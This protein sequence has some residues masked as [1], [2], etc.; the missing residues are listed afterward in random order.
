M[1]MKS[2]FTI[3]LL[4]CTFALAAQNQKIDPTVEVNRDYQG[5]MMEI[6]KG[7]LNTATADSLNSFN[8]DF[9]Y[10]FFNKPYKDMYEFSAVPSASIPEMDTIYTPWLHAKGGIGF[11]FTAQ[12]SILVSPRLTK[13]N[14]LNMMGDFNLF[15]GKVPEIAIMEGKAQESGRKVDNKEYSYGVGAGY[16]HAWRSGELGISV[17]F[18]GGYSTYYGYRTNDAADAA[19]HSYTVAGIEMGIKSSGA[20]KYG[21]KMNYALKGK[22]SHTSDKGM[23]ELQENIFSISAEAGPTVGRY[24]KFMAAVSVEAAD[25]GNAA[26]YTAGLFGITPQY[27]FE[28]GKLKVNLGIKLQGHFGDREKRDRYHSYI[29]PAVDLSFNL[30]PRNLWL[31]G[32]VD[33]GNVLNSYTGTL[34]QNRHISPDHTPAG[35]M[36]GSIPLDV[37]GGFKGRFTDRFSF[38]VFAGYTIHKGLQQFYHDQRNGWSNTF[39]SNTNRFGIGASAVV[40]T[41]RFQ[42]EISALHSFWTKGKKSSFINGLAPVGFPSIEGE[43][44]IRY[45]WEKKVYATVECTFRGETG[46]LC[47]D[48]AQG[49][50]PAFADLKAGVEWV[51]S[52]VVTFW[53][54]GCNLLDA[55]LQYHPF[56]AGRRIGFYAGIIVEL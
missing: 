52:P 44:R 9:S 46:Y 27:R 1:K 3:L 48:A 23:R 25:A 49:T 53:L 43:A 13:G 38:S 21:Q 31:Y 5:K 41:E 55:P 34:A 18:N 56:Y 35:L 17:G 6:T 42:G 8:L 50:V 22:F 11:P 28:N 12:A 37:E 29:F 26:H 36:T 2:T 10:S 20:G 4:C 33:G 19:D 14:Y 7:K 30:L 47:L 51:Y 16:T 15:N 39:Y 45:N 24:N 32:K 54:Q 40:A